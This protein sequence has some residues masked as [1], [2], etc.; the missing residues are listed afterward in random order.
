VQARTREPVLVEERDRAVRA[1]DEECPAT[2]SSAVTACTLS[3]S[4]RS[5]RAVLASQ[6]VLF[7]LLDVSKRSPRRSATTRAR[8]AGA[9]AGRGNSTGFPVSSSKIRGGSEYGATIARPSR[10]ASTW[11]PTDA[12]GSPSARTHRDANGS[13]ISSGPYACVASLCCASRCRVPGTKTAGDVPSSNRPA[14]LHFSRFQSSCPPSSD[15]SACVPSLVIEI[16]HRYP[17]RGRPS[18]NR[19]M[20]FRARS[21]TS[22]PPFS[23]AT[24][25]CLPLG[26]NATAADRSQRT[27]STVSTPVSRSSVKRFQLRAKAA[28]VPSSERLIVETGRSSFASAKDR[29]S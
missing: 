29:F 6:S 11:Q 7:D 18:A 19:S 28:R 9:E 20:T 14:K 22:I 27:S 1:R 25:R 2:G 26:V 4:T 8:S 23:R 21:Q 17:L 16:E 15:T 5:G 13:K 12:F 24:T 3:P 10:A